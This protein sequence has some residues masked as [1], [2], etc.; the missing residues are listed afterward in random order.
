MTDQETISS[1]FA[2]SR[3]QEES[4]ISDRLTSSIKTG[5]G[6]S[7]TATSILAPLKMPHHAQRVGTDG[8]Q[9]SRPMGDMEPVANAVGAGVEKGLPAAVAMILYSITVTSIFHRSVVRITEPGAVLEQEPADPFVLDLLKRL[10]AQVS[11]KVLSV[12]SDLR[13]IVTFGIRVHADLEP[14]DS[15]RDTDAGKRAVVPSK[16]NA[17]TSPACV[18]PVIAGVQIILR[19]GPHCSRALTRPA[20]AA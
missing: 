3:G 4:G 6:K 16:G 9:N 19:L 18:K 8:P 1:L 10:N 17:R 2:L 11:V 5:R 14:G 13:A 15:S 12:R 7:N 20:A